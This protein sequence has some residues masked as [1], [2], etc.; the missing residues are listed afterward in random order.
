MTS[1]VIVELLIFIAYF[2]EHNISYQLCKFQLSR[3]SGSNFTEGVE[4][5]SPRE[6][7]PSAFWVKQ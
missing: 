7:K 3:M 2:V 6:K 4:N 5:T 1:F